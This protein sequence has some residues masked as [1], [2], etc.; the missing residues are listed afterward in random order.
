MTGML[1]SHVIS[2]L[3]TIVSVYLDPL[4]RMGDKGVQ[5]RVKISEVSPP[6]VFSPEAWSFYDCIR[7]KNDIPTQKSCVVCRFVRSPNEHFPFQTIR[8]T[9]FAT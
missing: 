3:L 9:V 7:G 6:V 5:V 4:R 2:K 1:L 8:G